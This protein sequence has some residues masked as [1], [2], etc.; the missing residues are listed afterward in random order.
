MRSILVSLSSVYCSTFDEGI[1]RKINSLRIRRFQPKTTIPSTLAVPAWDA[2]A[3]AVYTSAAFANFDSGSPGPVPRV[4]P[5]NLLW[6]TSTEEV[7]VYIHP[8][9]VIELSL[10]DIG[11]SEHSIVYRIGNREDWAIKYHSACYG[12][13]LRSDPT[14]QE[15]YFLQLLNKIIPHV[16]HKFIYMSGPFIPTKPSKFKQVSPDIQCGKDPERRPPTVRYLITE[17]VGDSLWGYLDDTDNGRIPFMRAIEL[18]IDILRLIR[19]IHSINIVHGDV[20]PGNIAFRND[21][22]ILLI[23]FGR[24]RI[25]PSDIPELAPTIICH[26]HLS[27]W[28][29]LRSQALSSFRDDIFRVYLIMATMIYGDSFNHA[30]GA[31]CSAELEPDRFTKY[32]D[33][34][35]KS[36]FFDSSLIFEGRMNRAV[37]Y[38]FTLSGV[39]PTE[40]QRERTKISAVLLESLD[41]VRGLDHAEIPDHD[42]LIRLLKTIQN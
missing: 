2:L 13:I 26:R 18:G 42:F 37:S 6:E 34:K 19:D 31:L 7:P 36:N 38:R 40:R 9:G 35:D 28:Q 30:Q 16:T 21:R 23:D 11:S 10:P 3:K 33:F 17:R 27:P 29:S 39:L 25:G 15:A 32:M 22:D 4:I 5:S 14:L 1:L 20:H 24:S 8:D 12:L 41:Y